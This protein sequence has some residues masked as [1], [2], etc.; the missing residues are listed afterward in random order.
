MEEQIKTTSVY[1]IS[2][3]LKGA[4]HNYQSLWDRLKELGAIQILPTEWLIS[5]PNR[6]YTQL[7]GAVAVNLNKHLVKG[8][9]LLVQEVGRDRA[10]YNL[11]AGDLEAISLILRDARF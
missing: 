8:D 6:P 7:A 10:S 4:E 3:D 1:R 9:T 11:T 2:L 5:K